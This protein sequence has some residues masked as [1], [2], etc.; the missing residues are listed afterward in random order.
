MDAKDQLFMKLSS[1][2]SH[3]L[4]AI[5][6]KILRLELHVSHACNLACDSCSHY[7][8]HPHRGSL[9]PEQAD[10]WMGAWRDRIDVAEF[11]LLGGEPTMHPRL[12]EFVGL[13]RKHWPKTLI[14]VITNGFFLHRHPKLP[15]ALADAGNSELVLSIHHDGTAYLDRMRPIFDLLAGWQRDHGTIVHTW[16]SHRNWTRRYHGFGA[17]ILPFEDGKPRQSWEICP[18]KDCKQ[19]HDGKLWKCPPLAYLGMQK[20]KYELSEKWDRY[21]RYQPLDIACTNSELDD[22]LALEDET[23]CSMCPGKR[24]PYPLPNPLRRSHNTSPADAC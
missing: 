9:D 4:R 22:F 7:S 11:H 8:N 19:L 15:T 16:Q 10:R 21:L 5:P 17:T 20:A 13:V 6:A 18:A 12:P 24:Q 14:R 1:D 2:S 3:T 23:F